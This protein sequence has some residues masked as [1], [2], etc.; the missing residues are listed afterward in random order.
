[1]VSAEQDVPWKALFKA[2]CLMVE[3]VATMDAG[4]LWSVDC[5]GVLLP[6]GPQDVDI[7]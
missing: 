2:P 6:A 1:M 3:A 5:P 7:L 4:R